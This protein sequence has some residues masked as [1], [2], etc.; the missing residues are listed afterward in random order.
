MRSRLFEVLIFAIVLLIST[1]GSSKDKP[2]PGV[3]PFDRCA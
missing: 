3:T 1:E 2:G